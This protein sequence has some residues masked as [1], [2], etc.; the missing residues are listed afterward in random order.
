M[1]SNKKLSQRSM[2]IITRESYNVENSPAAPAWVNEFSTALANAFQ[3]SSVEVY[4]PEASTVYDQ[5]SSIMGKKPKYSTVEAAVEDMKERSGLT[6]Y[7]MKVQSAEGPTTDT[8]KRAQIKPVAIFEQVPQIKST[9]DNYLEDTNGN[10]SLPAII[11][12]IKSI[13]KPDVMEESAW[14]DPAFLQY[15]SDQN[16]RVKQKYPNND[17]DY[18][19]LGKIPTFNKDEIDPSNT[20]ALHALAPAVVTAQYDALVLSFRKK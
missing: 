8:K 6:A 7:L 10:L 11:E 18:V 19:N 20:D 15:I 13:H 1:S 14:D 12:K 5:I 16:T 9:V 4:R 3:K 17:S 2:P